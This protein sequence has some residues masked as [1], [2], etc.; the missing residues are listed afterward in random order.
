MCNTFIN[1]YPRWLRICKRECID[2]RMKL[3]FGFIKLRKGCLIYGLLLIIINSVLIGIGSC[4]E[5]FMY[6]IGGCDG[7]Y[8]L[9]V[10]EAGVLFGCFLLDV[11]CGVIL[12]M[13][14]SLVSYIFVDHHFMSIYG[15]HIS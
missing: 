6:H 15:F 1:F 5:W 7:C 12:S 3:M 14:I 8:K 2:Y 11:I 4:Y 10:L 13:T 9:S